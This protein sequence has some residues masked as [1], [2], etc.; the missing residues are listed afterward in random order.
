M[1]DCFLSRCALV[2]IMPCASSIIVYRNC[3]WNVWM[4]TH[5]SG[6]C[7][8]FPCI[9]INCLSCSL[10][11]HLQSFHAP[12]HKPWENA[13]KL[14]CAC[15]ASMHHTLSIWH[16]DVKQTYV[17]V[18]FGFAVNTWM[19]WM[20]L[21]GPTFCLLFGK[22]WTVKAK[23]FVFRHFQTVWKMLRTVLTYKRSCVSLSRRS[24]QS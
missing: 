22:V 6:W 16:K 7:S 13:S 12:Q 17:L 10:P 21:F 8:I 3:K 1:S 20:G 2:E 23:L 9:S 4:W 18:Q 15:V 5:G 19:K 24:D 11:A 14:F